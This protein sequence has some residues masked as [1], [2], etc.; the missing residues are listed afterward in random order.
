VARRTY[1]I[2]FTPAADRDFRDLSQNVQR[3]L[4]PKID[5]LAGNPRPRGVETLA[6]E[7]D[8]PRIRAGA[9]RIVYQI[10]DEVLVIVLVR[11]RYRRDVYRNL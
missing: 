8:L 6:G 11:I 3:P 10:R 5:A 7:K 1:R 2:K 9:S 4:R